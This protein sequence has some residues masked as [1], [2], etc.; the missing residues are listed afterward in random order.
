MK[1]RRIIGTILYLASWIILFF[2]IL[3]AV[4]G[5]SIWSDEAFSLR[6]AECTWKEIIEITAMDVHPPLYYLLLKGGIILFT[7]LFRIDVIAAARLVSAVPYVILLIVIGT[8]VRKT[9]G[10]WQAGIMSF[11]L[12]SMPNFLTYG[13]EIRMYSWA[14][15]F[16]AA[17]YIFMR[18]IIENNSS[19]AWILFSIS[20]LLAAYTH[21]FAA[22]A[23]VGLYIGLFFLM[24]PQV[25]R[26]F[27]SAGSIFLLYS[28]WMIVFLR[29]VGNVQNSYW[30]RPITGNDIKGYIYYFAAPAYGTWHIDE[31]TIC[32]V[33]IT[34]I[35]GGI[36]SFLSKESRKRIHY[37]LCG[38]WALFFPLAVGILAS[39]LI[40]PVFVSRYMVP[41]SA[42]FWIGIAIIIGEL[43]KKKWGY[44][45]LAVLLPACL[46]NLFSFGRTEKRWQEEFENTEE[47][48]ENLDGNG[49]I[50]SEN[51]QL[52]YTLDVYLNSPQE[53][54][55]NYEGNQSYNAIF[56]EVDL[57]GEEID[58][59]TKKSIEWVIQDEGDERLTD[60]L[61]REGKDLQKLGTYST[62][63]V[64]FSLY[65]AE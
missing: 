5:N 52:M 33:F 37:A 35:A 17:A 54:I 28:P 10:I 23:V 65:R 44:V 38:I 1:I 30:I 58:E 32:A 53:A 51:P 27:C 13:L 25:L 64:R 36:I 41:A 57:L 56:P 42:C 24:W 3:A 11:L 50:I 62:K 46:L 12:V 34:I 19:T 4:T 22:V 45:L 29:Q 18:R 59:E 60:K 47:A 9:C 49:L 48:L 6:L 14:L 7:S 26:L 31:I 16:V 55:W 8:D 43:S 40:K 2:L 15:L 20:C 63:W 61:Q 39:I 21:Y